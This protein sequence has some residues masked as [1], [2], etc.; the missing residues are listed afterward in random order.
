M[1]DVSLQLRE[2]STRS[3][4]WS[5]GLVNDNCWIRYSE[6]GC[7]L[8]HLVAAVATRM[9]VSQWEKKW[10][11]QRTERPFTAAFRETL[12]MVLALTMALMV[13]IIHGSGGDL[14]CYSIIKQRRK[15][16]FGGEGRGT[17]CWILRMSDSYSKGR[18]AQTVWRK[19][20]GQSKYNFNCSFTSFRNEKYSMCSLTTWTSSWTT[21]H[22][23]LYKLFSSNLHDLDSPR[24]SS[25]WLI[26]RGA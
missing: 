10:R 9:H 24:F 7:L 26:S 21:F 3:P 23:P 17:I 8:Q 11:W 2:I 14:G 5:I 25:V 22:Q 13:A 12:T 6:N 20:M 19:K 16:F 18:V 15:G 4:W 1:S